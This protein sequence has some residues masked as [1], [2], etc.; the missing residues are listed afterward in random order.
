MLSL[1]VNTIPHLPTGHAFDS[2]EHILNL[3]RKHP[4]KHP[5]QVLDLTQYVKVERVM[6][7]CIRMALA[8]CLDRIVSDSL[9]MG[10]SYCH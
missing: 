8:A 10:F 3:A 2:R 9:K 4:W 1:S 6:S 7:F 5:R